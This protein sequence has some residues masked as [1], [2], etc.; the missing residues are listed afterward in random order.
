MVLT[1][2]SLN[3]LTNINS[4]NRLTNLN[5]RLATLSGSNRLSSST[6]ETKASVTGAVA[7][8]H[9]LNAGVRVPLHLRDNVSDKFR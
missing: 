8:R 4:L 6:T 1:Q 9:L 3:R 5:S 2:N 7:R